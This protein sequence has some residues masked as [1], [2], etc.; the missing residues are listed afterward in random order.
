VIRL[1]TIKKGCNIPPQ[2]PD[3]FVTSH[4]TVVKSDMKS[5]HSTI[6]KQSRDKKIKVSRHMARS[7]ARRK[8]RCADYLIAF[9]GGL[10][11]CKELNPSGND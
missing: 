9:E 1:K 10:F 2:V 5:E 4:L 11:K 3:Y 7:E 6:S 8:K